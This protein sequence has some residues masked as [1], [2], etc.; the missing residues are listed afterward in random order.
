MMTLSGP[1]SCEISQKSG[2]KNCAVK[3]TKLSE[4]TL[5]YDYFVELLPRSTVYSLADDRFNLSKSRCTH[6]VRN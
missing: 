6:T 2:F 1:C 3:V 4:L 5:I